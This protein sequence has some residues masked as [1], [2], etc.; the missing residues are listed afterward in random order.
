ML[1]LTIGT[2]NLRLTL[3]N[4][5]ALASVTLRLTNQTTGKVTTATV[6]SPAYD[7][8]LFRGQISINTPPYSASSIELT[9]PDNPQGFYLAELRSGTTVMATTVAYFETQPAATSY[10]SPST[11]TAYE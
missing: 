3:Q 10:A 7:G 5:V 11:Y 4:P 1:Q 9:E 2:N 6:V 8:R